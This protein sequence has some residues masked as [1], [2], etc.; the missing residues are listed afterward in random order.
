GWRNVNSTGVGISD[1]RVLPP[2]RKPSPEYHSRRLI[3]FRT[4]PRASLRIL[5][6]SR[7]RSRASSSSRRRPI[8][9]ARAS[10]R[11]RSGG[12]VAR[13]PGYAACAC[14]TACATSAAV[15]CGICPRTSEE[16]AVLTSAITRVWEAPWVMLIHA[17]LLLRGRGSE[18]TGGASFSLA[19]K[20]S[21]PGKPALDLRVLLR[22]DLR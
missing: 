15:C 21:C 5:P 11:P 16:S 19:R 13:Q 6:S 9:A 4:S 14:S 12:E 2:I 3:P 1:G 22:G 20:K 7:V 18:D 17:L 8:S 10:T